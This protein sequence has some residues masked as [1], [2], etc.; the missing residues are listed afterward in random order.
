VGIALKSLSLHS[1]EMLDYNLLAHSNLF[2]L[3]RLKTLSIG[4]RARIPWREFAPHVTSVEELD[5]VLNGTISALAPL[6]S[7]S[8]PSASAFPNLTT[9]RLSLPVWIPA[10]NRL[11]FAGELFAGLDAPSAKMT[12]NA[13]NTHGNTKA[14]ASGKLRTLVLSADANG[15]GMPDAAL[16]TLLDGVAVELGVELELEVDAESYAGI[17]PFFPRLWDVGAVRASP[18][19]Y[20]HH[21]NSCFPD[22]S[23]R[24][25]LPSDTDM[26]CI[27][28]RWTDSGSREALW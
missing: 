4:W 19:F 2:D 20:S 11:A 12:A 18:V 22:I 16:C 8:F 1:T 9:L 10:R 26:L 13:M 24:W 27:Q 3:S 7:L 28:V 6:L 23:S 5:V 25:T 17:W 21:D 15:N 14:K